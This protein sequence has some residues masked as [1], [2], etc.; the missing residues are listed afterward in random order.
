MLCSYEILNNLFPPPPPS[1]RLF[2]HLKTLFMPGFDSPRVKGLTLNDIYSGG[3]IHPENV[4]S[5][6]ILHNILEIN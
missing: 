1:I 4:P 3:K 2:T 6:I 5:C